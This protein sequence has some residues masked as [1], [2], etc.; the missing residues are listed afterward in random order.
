MRKLFSFLAI[1]I[2]TLTFA[3]SCND[4]NDVLF[5]VQEIGNLSDGMTLIN[6]FGVEYSITEDISNQNKLEL[7]GNRVLA[8]LEVTNKKEENKYEARFLG[9][10]LVSVKDIISSETI[11]EP[12]KL[13]TSPVQLVHGWFSGN[14]INII[15]A[16][17]KKQD[18]QQPHE[19]SLYYDKKN[20][21]EDNIIFYLRHQSN[22]D[23]FGDEGVKKEETSLFADY[24]SFELGDIITNIDKKTVNV[25]IN[26]DW[27]ND[28]F[29]IDPKIENYY[30]KGILTIGEHLNFELT[31]TNL[32]DNGMN[33]Y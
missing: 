15:S 33:L 12:E 1:G 31:E 2:M 18:S 5:T 26:W 4:K 20:S 9:A 13:G 19:I 30:M 29:G 3:T 7:I 21:D 32:T 28:G 6:D 17:L 16:Y 14:Y 22:G 27:Y 24:S 23:S 10:R 11:G 8:Y 25:T